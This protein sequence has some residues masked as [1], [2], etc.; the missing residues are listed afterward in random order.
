M[1]VVGNGFSMLDDNTT[2]NIRDVPFTDGTV[3][4][5]SGATLNVS[6]TFDVGDSSTVNNYGSVDVCGSF[7][8]GDFT[9]VSNYGSATFSVDGGFTLGDYGD[10]SS[11]TPR[12]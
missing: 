8:G 11:T 5:E 3:T 1:E 2:V 7:L 12:P 4:V 6:C 10:V 9:S